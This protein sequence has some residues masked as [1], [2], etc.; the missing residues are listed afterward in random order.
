M[1]EG[2]PGPLGYASAG[3]SSPALVSSQAHTG[4]T[5]Q[6]SQSSGGSG[7]DRPTSVTAP[8]EPSPPVNT[9]R[10]QRR[11]GV[12][13]LRLQLRAPTGS[14]GCRPP[15]H[16]KYPATLT[17]PVC[18]VNR[19]RQAESC[20]VGDRETPISALP[21]FCL[22]LINGAIW[23]EVIITAKNQWEASPGGQ[24]PGPLPSARPAPGKDTPTPGWREGS[25]AS[26][27]R[28]PSRSPRLGS[29]PPGLSQQRSCLLFPQPL[30]S[31]VS[32]AL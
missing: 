2:P 26:R 12:W 30:A 28:G 22:P 10:G 32:S 4:P 25:S 20:P 9:L 5:V 27:G 15:L 8:A 29:P 24:E 1:P 16:T 19:G 18:T 6:G 17:D 13:G 31:E 3:S 21:L 14:R 11:P 7:T 23:K